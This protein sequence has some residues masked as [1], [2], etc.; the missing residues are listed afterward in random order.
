[1]R[2]YKNCIGVNWKVSFIAERKGIEMSFED[3]TIIHYLEFT[4]EET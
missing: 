1:M 4:E 2:A 3:L